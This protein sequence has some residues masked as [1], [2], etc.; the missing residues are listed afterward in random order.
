MKY[1]FGPH[2]PRSGRDNL[3]SSAE[4]ARR[5]S[6]CGTRARVARM[7]QATPDDMDWNSQYFCCY[8]NAVVTIQNQILP[9]TFTINHLQAI[10][11]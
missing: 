3:S 6:M 4:A 5:G 10:A 11:K 7:E 1:E 8:A 2:W 9:H